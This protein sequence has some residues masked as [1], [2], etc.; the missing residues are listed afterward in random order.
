LR[1]VAT[2][3]SGIGMAYRLEGREHEPTLVLGVELAKQ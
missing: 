3:V 2:V 1:L